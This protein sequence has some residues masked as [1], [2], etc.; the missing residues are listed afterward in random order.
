[1]LAQRSSTTL[2]E[3]MQS[4]ELSLPAHHVEQHCLPEG[5]ATCR[6]AQQDP[7]AAS[8]QVRPR[9]LEAVLELAVRLP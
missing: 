7:P 1:M 6:A 8:Q 5:L 3:A 2:P 4:V 9:F